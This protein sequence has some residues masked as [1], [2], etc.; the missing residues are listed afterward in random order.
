MSKARRPP[1]I[2]TR[3][4][5][6]LALPPEVV[7]RREARALPYAAEHAA[8]QRRKMTEAVEPKGLSA[9]IHWV[10]WAYKQEPPIAIHDRDELADDG[11]P[12]WTG[13]FATW[14]NG[15]G[16]GGGGSCGEDD[17][18]YLRTPLRCALYVM[19]GRFERAPSAKMADFLLDIAQENMAVTEVALLHEITPAWVHAIVTEVG[20]RKLWEL[21]T[22]VRR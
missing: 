7:A 8:S 15:V 4:H 3:P 11:T 10:R 9:L 14:V 18:G 12:R 19:H 13:D 17:D 2:H 5:V 22:P 6:P 20:L 16:N 21:Y 1:T